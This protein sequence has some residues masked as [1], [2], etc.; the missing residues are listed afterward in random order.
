MPWLE[1]SLLY[2]CKR[3]RKDCSIVAIGH[4]L[5]NQFKSRLARLPWASL[6][7]PSSSSLGLK[8]GPRDRIDA[9]M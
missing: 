4:M 7:L 3:F 2:Y 5:S 1:N 8:L 6:L 9:Q